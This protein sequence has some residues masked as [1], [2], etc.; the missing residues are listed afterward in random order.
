[1]IIP[2]KLL[3]VH[4]VNAFI[5]VDVTLGMD[6]LDG[7]FVSAAL[8]GLAAF[9]PSPQPFEHA[10]A[11]GDRERRTQRADVAAEEALD[12]KPRTQQDGGIENEW[13]LAEELQDDRG[14]ERF[15]LRKL[16]GEG[17]RI[18]RHPEQEQEDDVLD[19]P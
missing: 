7:A 17:H 6:R 13:P 19:G 5:N 3:A 4:A 8:A 11:S 14:L 9:R 10:D 18:E 2:V 12:E 16:L 1:M 15:D